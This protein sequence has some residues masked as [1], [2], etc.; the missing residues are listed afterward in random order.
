MLGNS[1]IL[2]SDQVTSSATAASTTLSIALSASTTY[3]FDCLLYVTNHTGSNWNVQLHNFSTF[4]V[5]VIGSD[6]SVVPVFS[7]G[8]DIL[9]T[10][11]TQTSM[12]VRIYG[13]V[14]VGGSATTL[15]IDF[16]DP[17]A[18]GTL[19]IKAGSWLRVSKG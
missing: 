7:A 4:T 9:P 13:T 1:Q 14:S 18:V 8:A 17:A 19:T 3:L 11:Q 15:Q 2:T 6:I 16:R 12:A 10:P 5:E